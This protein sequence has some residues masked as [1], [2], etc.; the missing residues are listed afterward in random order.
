MFVL[1]VSLPLPDVPLPWPFPFLFWSLFIMAILKSL[2]SR[3]YDGFLK[4]N[5]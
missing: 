2:K 1:C 4:E 5:G 3:S